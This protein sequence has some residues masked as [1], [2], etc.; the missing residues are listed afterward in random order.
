MTKADLWA[1]YCKRNPQ[2]ER[3]GNVTLSTRGLKALFDQTYDQGFREG[4]DSAPVKPPPSMDSDPLN[5]F[6][7]IFNPPSK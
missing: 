2:F 7:D 3:E 1:H 6:K 4:G 5:I